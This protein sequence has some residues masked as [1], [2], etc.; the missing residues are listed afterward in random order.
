MR[1]DFIH[2]LASEIGDLPFTVDFQWSSSFA[3]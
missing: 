3:S 2:E 1:S